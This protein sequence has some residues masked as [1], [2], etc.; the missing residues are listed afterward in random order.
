MVDVSTEI[1]INLPKEKVTEFASDPANVPNWC[2]HIKSVEWNNDAPLRAGV[3]LVFNERIM[4]RPHKQ[5]YE[6]VEIIPGQKVI[7]KS[8]SN[9]MRME[10]TV[11][12]QAINENTTCMTLRNRGIPVAFSKPIAPLL[13]LAI[14][15][16]SRRN[17]K[18]LKR[19][20]ELNYRRLVV[21]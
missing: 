20:L 12:W 5:V 16:A 18:Q 8:Q 7:M 1:I 3:K 6:V 10:T 2:T 19:M 4:R 9:G 15:K 21:L 14:R 17:L 13:K 11:A